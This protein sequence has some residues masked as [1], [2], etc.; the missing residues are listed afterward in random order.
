VSGDG[1]GVL[2]YQVAW[3]IHVMIPVSR[4]MLVLSVVC[5]NR[6]RTGFRYFGKLS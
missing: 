1:L 4:C 6:T 2:V 3:M 5:T